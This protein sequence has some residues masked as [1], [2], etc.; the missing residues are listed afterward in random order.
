MLPYMLLYV[1][2]PGMRRQ[3]R[4]GVKP[5]GQSF[6]LRERTN[7]EES[8]IP[9]ASEAEGGEERTVRRTYVNC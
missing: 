6:P 2:N 4:R 7:R 5:G 9:Q 1:F 8:S 3:Q